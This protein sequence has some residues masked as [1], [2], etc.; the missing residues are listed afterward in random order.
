M[1]EKE[2]GA[3]K[4]DEEGKRGA[5]RAIMPMRKGKMRTS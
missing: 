1:A 5:I 2:S 3:L 4:E